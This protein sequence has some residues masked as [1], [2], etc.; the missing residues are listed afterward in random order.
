MT[1]YHVVSG[2]DPKNST[3]SRTILEVFLPDGREA[4]AE[5][6][7]GDEKTDLA[8]ISKSI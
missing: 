6:K 4:K 1:N 3:S 2:A 7:G 8:V 5:F